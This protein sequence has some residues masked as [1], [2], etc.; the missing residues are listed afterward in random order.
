MFEFSF[1]MAGA[2]GAGVSCA[3]A[4]KIR[5]TYGTHKVVSQC[6]LPP[7]LVGENVESTYN[8]VLCFSSIFNH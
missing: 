8:G 4:T 2:T 3:V 1:S 7:L 6:L 5:E